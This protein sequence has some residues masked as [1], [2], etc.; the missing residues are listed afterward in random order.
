MSGGITKGDVSCVDV[1]GGMAKADVSYV[2]VQMCV[3]YE[4]HHI[5]MYI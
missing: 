3:T 2:N 4:V 1:S 5:N